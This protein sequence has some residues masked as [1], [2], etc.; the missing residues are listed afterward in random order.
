[1]RQ[2]SNKDSVFITA[3]A[4]E[5]KNSPVLMRHGAVAVANGRIIAKGHNDYHYKCINKINGRIYL[6][7]RM[8]RFFT[9]INETQK[10][11]EYFITKI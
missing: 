11:T 6:S 4:E 1:M 10:L 7:C 9:Q 8:C 2:V 3:A 5:A